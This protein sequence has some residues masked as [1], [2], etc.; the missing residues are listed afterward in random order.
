MSDPKELCVRRPD[1]CD[2]M[3]V[4]RE[5]AWRDGAQGTGT[6]DMAELLRK[7]AREPSPTVPESPEPPGPPPP[8]PPVPPDFQPQ[9]G[10]PIRIK[11]LLFSSYWRIVNT[12]YASLNDVVVVKNP[13]EVYVLR[14]DKRAD[15]WLEPPDSLY[16]AGR[17]E[18]QY[19][20]YGFVLQRSIELIAQMFRSGKYAIILGCDP[21]AIVRSP[22]RF[23]LQQIWRYEG[24]IVNA[25]PAR[26]AV[27]R[28]DNAK[29]KIA[30]KYFGKGCPIYSLWAN[31]LLQLIGVPVQLTC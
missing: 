31:Q 25:S 29:S 2:S 7:M 6:V 14:R 16:I 20:I 26:I 8:A 22:R 24:Y 10:A 15:R 11:G 1:L 19:C 4:A 28:L 13:Q 9:W 5:E 23:E 12:P 21:R 18:R 3:A 30:V 17:V 27:V